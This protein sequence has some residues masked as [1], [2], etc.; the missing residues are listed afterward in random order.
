MCLRVTVY[1]LGKG[2][3]GE[4]VQGYNVSLIE[5]ARLHWS[6]ALSLSLPVSLPVCLPTSPSRFS[7]PFSPPFSTPF[8]PQ[9]WCRLRRP[10]P[11]RRGSVC[12]QRA[13]ANHQE[14]DRGDATKGGDALRVWR[15]R[16]T[17]ASI[18][19][20][21]FHDGSGRQRRRKF[22]GVQGGGEVIRAL[23]K[24]RRPPIRHV[25][26]GRKPEH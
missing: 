5:A 1:R 18:E 11:T 3:S 20:D 16:G 21:L 22:G 10:C 14:G 24:P 6:S 7:P 15:A 4:W 23:W 2:V 9:V 26:H 19:T 17:K 13:G 12:I 8:S 25:G